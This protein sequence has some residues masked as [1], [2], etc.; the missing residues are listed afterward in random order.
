[1]EKRKNLSAPASLKALWWA[2][3]QQINTFQAQSAEAE[4]GIFP[5]DTS[6]NR[7]YYLFYLRVYKEV[8]FKV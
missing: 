1:M 8:S 4:G 7:D 3:D 6:V 2:H 5:L